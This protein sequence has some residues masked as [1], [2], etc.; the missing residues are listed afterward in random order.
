MLKYFCDRCDEEIQEVVATFVWT[1]AQVKDWMPMFPKEEYERMMLCSK[2]A[3]KLT[4]FLKREV[5]T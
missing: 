2:C 1:Q 3:E 4:A 5:V